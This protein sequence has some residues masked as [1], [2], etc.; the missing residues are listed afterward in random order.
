[1]VDFKEDPLVQAIDSIYQAVESPELWPETIRALGELVG[2]GQDFLLAGRSPEGHA[3]D[4][5]LNAHLRSTRSHSM[6]LSKADLKALDEYIDEYGELIT[7]F[8]KILFLS[9]LWA[10][11]NVVQRESMGLRMVQ[12]YLIA[13]E[14]PSG[15]AVLSSLGLRKMM[16]A[17][18]EDGRIFTVENL[19]CIRLLISHLDRAL[20]LQIRLVGLRLHTEMASNALNSL[21]LGVIFIDTAGRPL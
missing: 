19:R 8:L 1:M 13:P 6:P 20:R 3:S 11:D 2:G 18:W 4:Y 14:H 21:T 5:T 17:L 12:Q 15:V 7:R 16:A 10:Q 9:S